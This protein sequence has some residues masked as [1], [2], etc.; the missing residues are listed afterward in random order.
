[1]VEKK[2]NSE[3]IKVTE[4]NILL[5]FQKC[6]EAEHLNFYLTGGTLLGAV[7]HKG[8]IPWD[9]DIDVCMPRPDYDRFL[10]LYQA[11]LA[12]PAHLKLAGF[13]TGTSS[14]PFIKI[15]DDR[16]RCDNDFD[17]EGDG[18]GLWIDVF[19]VDGLPNSE[20]ET[21][22]LYKKAGRVRQILI[23]GQA[24]WGEGQ[25]LFRRLFKCVVIPISRLVGVKRCAKKLIKIA[26]SRSYESS[27]YVGCV[28]WGLY[29]LG[30]RMKKTEYEDVVT[31]TFENHSF[32]TYSCWQSYLTKSYGDYMTLPPEDKRPTH[33]MTAW[34]RE[35][36]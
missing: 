30:E 26:K 12:L 19:P 14:Q 23:W 35:K 5:A 13:E 11:G 27:N 32:P 28:V 25:N 29:G 7:R 21:E 4:L 1:M 9:D 33:N 17:T 6:C 18:I 22:K 31:M 34:R 8:F 2:L 15:Y 20:R 24:K 10:Q 16:T 36:D 3:E